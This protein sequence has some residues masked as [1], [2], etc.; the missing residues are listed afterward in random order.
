MITSLSAGLFGEGPGLWS[1]PLRIAEPL[2]PSY[3]TG[4][5]R[6]YRKTVELGEDD[7]GRFGPDEWLG[8]IVVLLQVAV[9][10]GLEVGDRTEHAAR[11]IRWRVILEKQLSTALSQDPEVGV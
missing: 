1:R 9:D 2:E 6:R 3:C 8:I 11:R 10:H 5:N 4:L 7:I